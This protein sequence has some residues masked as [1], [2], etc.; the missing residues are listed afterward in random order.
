M[1][2]RLLALPLLA[3]ASLPAWASETAS[4]DGEGG[5][6]GREVLARVQALRE[7]YRPRLQT[8]RGRAAFER[9]LASISRRLHRS[10]DRPTGVTDEHLGSLRGL[11][12]ATAAFDAALAR[13][14]ASPS[15]ENKAA[16]DKAREG[17][18]ASS[19]LLASLPAVL[20]P[21]WVRP[22]G[23]GGGGEGEP[24]RR[25]P[26]GL[27]AFLLELGDALGARRTFDA[28]AAADPK[29]SSALSGRAA[30]A[31]SMGD[32]AS[33]YGDARRALELDPGDRVALAT[34]KLAEG[35][36]GAS[37]VAGAPVSGAAEAKATAAS[38]A[39]PSPAA[40]AMPTS[41]PGALEAAR[42]NRE[43]LAAMKLGD[44]QAAL[45]AADRALAAFPANP[46]AYGV[47]AR[48]ALRARDYRAALDAA[49]LGLRLAPD[50]RGLLGIKA[51]A[52]NRLRQAPLAG[53]A[54]DR[55]LASDPADP[56]G[57]ANLAYARGL[58]GDRAGMLSLLRKA[59]EADP[60]YES[61]L[62]TALNMPADA[63]E[64]FLFPGEEGSA[65]L[66]KALRA[67]K[68]PAGGMDR[69]LLIALAGLAGGL[70]LA[71]PFAL[72]RRR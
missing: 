40:A 31:F 29:D 26:P 53:E 1:R 9:Q 35:R 6:L 8:E 12:D 22:E 68:E 54:A 34:F 10:L 18:M 21:E 32:A 25:R 19:K 37:G 14:M 11:W 46:V 7:E 23:S 67:A 47:R 2:G 20:R 27:G 36:G 28:A 61:S 63:P 62:G 51:R 16:L 71:A 72:M 50:D 49:E 38:A 17:L 48:L 65:E 30:A 43:A 52:A 69:R 15:P 33:A 3:L 44:R 13:A 58:N 5:L 55:L 56:E 59:A 41:S 24:G 42:W 39:T 64:L 66:L 45:A 70:V 60:Q 4:R 57:L